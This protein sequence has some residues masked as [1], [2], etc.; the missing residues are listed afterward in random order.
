MKEQ[1]LFYAVKYGG[2]WNRIKKALQENE[3][4]EKI[5]YDGNYLTI[6][7]EDYP[8]LLKRLVNPPWVIF[9]EGN[10]DLLKYSAVGIVGSRKN[11]DYGAMCCREIVKHLNRKHVV[12]SGLACGIDACAHFNCI[13]E[14]RYT[15]GV[16][17]CGLDICYPKVNEHL[18]QI[19]R[20]YH[21]ILS[22]YPKGT[23]PFAYHFPARNR[24]LAGLCEALI[25]V[26]AKKRS[27]TLISVN[28][29]LDIGLPVYCIPHRFLDENGESCN[30]LIQQGAEILVNFEDIEQI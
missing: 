18:Y 24:I 7:D 14:K 13:H 17:G 23:K 28:E 20:K 16:I 30:F 21:L 19:M 22:E 6:A 3:P 8:V 15:I 27:G 26:E 11:S 2:E 4:W 10:L 5:S 1:L 9:Y 12:V 29:A 25:V